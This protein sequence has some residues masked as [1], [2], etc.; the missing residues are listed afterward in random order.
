M[1]A[2]RLALTGG[3]T[4]LAAAVGVVA[5]LSAQ[6]RA[7]VQ[8]EV[9]SREEAFART[10]ADR[11][12]RAFTSFLSP[13]AVFI[14]RQVSRGPKEITETWKRFFDGPAAPFSWRPETV[15]VL[16]SG[17]LALSSGPVFGPDGK[18]IGT[19]NSTWRQEPDGVWRIVLDNG[20]P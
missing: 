6:D 16:D 14:G 3:A 13:E 18:R 15:E 17:T 2:R 10:M 4:V 9:R 20:C 8:R 11:D 1:I 7:A 5:P 12:L 19:F